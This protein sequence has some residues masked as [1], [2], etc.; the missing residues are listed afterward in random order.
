MSIEQSHRR[1]TS[2]RR[3][4]PGF[5][6]RN[7]DF[8]IKT[9]AEREAAAGIG[10]DP[11]TAS[12]KFAQFQRKGANQANVGARGLGIRVGCRN[13]FV[14]FKPFVVGRLCKKRF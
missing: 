10:L 3:T 8:S 2:A 14:Q 11:G 4:W 5:D 9:A 12:Q 1:T 7:A 13:L 6:N